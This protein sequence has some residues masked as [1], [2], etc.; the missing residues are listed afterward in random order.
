MDEE[1]REKL[2][3]LF[4][5]FDLYTSEW[6]TVNVDT[7]EGPMLGMVDDYLYRLLV[8]LLEKVEEEESND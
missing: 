2:E 1:L 8:E 6:P 7:P 3:E 5:Y 4:E